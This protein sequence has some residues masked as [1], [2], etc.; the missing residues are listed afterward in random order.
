MKTRPFHAR[1]SESDLEAIH[2]ALVSSGNA[3]LAALFNPKEGL[4]QEEAEYISRARAYCDHDL[5]VDEEPL[6]S[7][8]DDGAWV[9]AWVWVDGLQEILAVA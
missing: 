4:S 5:E 3:D 6:V 2:E 9:A 7:I 1:L 8:G